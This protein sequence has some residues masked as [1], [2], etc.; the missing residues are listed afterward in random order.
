MR[1]EDRL[2][3]RDLPHHLVVGVLE[4]ERLAR[5]DPFV[6]REPCG[7]ATENQGTDPV[8]V[9]EREQPVSRDEGDD[10]VRAFDPAVRARDRL[11]DA[12]RIQ[13]DGARRRL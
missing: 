1:D 2:A 4:H 11:E 8:G 12:V 3:R 5:D 9:A 10:G 13:V 7:T 6:A